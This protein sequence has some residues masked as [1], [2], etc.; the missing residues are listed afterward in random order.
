MAVVSVITNK[1]VSLVSREELSQ[2]IRY[3]PFSSGYGQGYRTYAQGPQFP[4]TGIYRLLYFMAN[5]EITYRT[6]RQIL[7]MYHFREG[8]E[9]TNQNKYPDTVR[10]LL[11]F[12]ERVNSNDQ[13]FIEVL[14]EIEDD[15]NIVDDAYLCFNRN[16]LI[17]SKSGDILYSHIKELYRGN[18]IYYRLVTAD[19]SRLGGVYGR[20]LSCE[21]DLF[22][23]RDDYELRNN[24]R[25]RQNPNVSPNVVFLLNQCSYDVMRRIHVCPVCGAR[26]Y[27][28]IVTVSLT[29]DGYDPV[30]YHIDKEVV[31][32]SKYSPSL[33]YGTSPIITAYN[34]MN[35]KIKFSTYLE[36]FLEYNRAPQGA[37]FINSSN[38]PAVRETMEQA[39]AKYAIDRYYLPIFAID[40]QSNGTI[41]QYVRLTPFPDELKQLD[42]ESKIRR[43]ISALLGV[44]NVMLNDLEGVGG[45]NSESLQVQVTDRAALAGQ[46]LY[47]TK[48]FPRTM[49]KLAEY[50][51]FEIGRDLSLI[52]KR[53][54]NAENET[55]M[56][57]LERQINIV[58]SI[59]DMGYEVEPD[60]ANL[61]G[62]D[63]KKL[64]PFSFRKLT[65][66][67]I[68][69]EEGLGL[70]DRGDKVTGISQPARSKIPGYRT[71]ILSDLEPEYVALVNGDQVPTTSIDRK[72]KTFYKVNIDMYNFIYIEESVWSGIIDK[73]TE[74]IE[75]ERVEREAE[76]FE[77]RIERTVQSFSPLVREILKMASCSL[78]KKTKSVDKMLDAVEQAVEIY[79]STRYGSGNPTGIIEA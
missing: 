36:S 69:E 35:T 13:T 54:D 20:C 70:M 21:V 39:A 63:N 56:V 62:Y 1:A 23:N 68:R 55:R 7:K 31:H 75:K 17:D 78:K 33:L 30:F 28:V 76:L 42:I 5:H 43:E 38:A 72:D 50:G 51:Q 48:L 59:K 79:V 60:F 52:V 47:N 34:E 77:A 57:N 25:L 27:D 71:K 22:R 14:F 19:N 37:I 3:D 29:P 26:L 16:Y 9:F 4:P 11:R 46:I 67:E 6:C 12:F 2:V 64:L 73:R 40:S 18:P 49:E 8:L 66:E 10:Q 58:L 15:L 41:A 61:L 45:L 24:V 74:R 65:K 53:T 44:Q 32:L